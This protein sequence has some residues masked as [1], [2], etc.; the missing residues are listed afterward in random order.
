[1]CKLD[2]DLG[3]IHKCCKF[4]DPSYKQSK[5]IAITAQFKA[6]SA[7]TLTLTQGQPNVTLSEMRYICPHDINIRYQGPYVPEI[8]WCTHTQTYVHTYI[9]PYAH[10]SLL[11]TLS[12]NAIGRHFTNSWSCL[13]TV[14]QPAIYHCETS[15]F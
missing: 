1:M 7:V 15:L 5:S 10:F 4:Y 8:S 12:Y 13:T 11:T 3:M 6:K 9:H 14:N 2:L